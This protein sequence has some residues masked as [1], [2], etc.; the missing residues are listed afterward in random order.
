MI[1]T[2]LIY[3]LLN[4][5]NGN[6]Y[7][8]QTTDFKTRMSHHKCLCSNTIISN[9]IKKYGWDTFDIVKLHENISIEKLDK[10][11]IYYIKLFNTFRGSG[12]NATPGG[13]VVGRGEDH[14]NYGGLSEEHKEKLRGPRPNAAGS[15]NH[16]WNKPRTPEEKKNISEAVKISKVNEIHHRCFLGKKK[17]KNYKLNGQ[18]FQGWRLKNGWSRLYV[19]EKSG[20]SIDSIKRWELNKSGISLYAR[21]KFQLAFNFDPIDR[22]ID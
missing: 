19:A 17:G 1:K 22:F 10:L 20:L 5:K 11:E 16:Q 4:R 8:G 13:C 18:L 3:M 6:A 15:N 2:G 9:A 14:P 12:Y 7:I 21:E